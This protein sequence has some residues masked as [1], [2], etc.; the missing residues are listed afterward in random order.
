MTLARRGGRGLYAR[1]P[2]VQQNS[3]E[4]GQQLQVRKLPEYLEPAQIDSLIA[5]VPY[6][7]PKLLV[8]LQW[9]AGLRISE[10]L[11]LDAE[12][13]QL[14]DEYPTLRVRKGKGNKPRLVPVH[15]ELRAALLTFMGFR[16]P[17]GPLIQA[18]RTTA[19]R[20]VKRAQEA[21]HI[22]GQ[23]GTHTLRHSAARHWLASGVPI[24][25][26]SIW[27]GHS[28][29]STTLI[30]LKILPDPRGSMDRVP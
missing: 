28:N 6:G 29:L 3:G 9:R 24:N 5:A 13:L 4:K 17:H 23:I 26:V 1:R 12:D 22:P 27:L 7:A 2:D 18:S 11:A 8:L 21:A 16:R 25:E 14:G 30:Y 19:W 20:W 10:A 15:P